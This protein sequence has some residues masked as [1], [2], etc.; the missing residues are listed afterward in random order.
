VQIS[1]IRSPSIRASG[2]TIAARLRGID[3]SWH[4]HNHRLPGVRRIAHAPRCFIGYRVGRRQQHRIG[5]VHVAA[6]D[7]LPLVADQR[8]DRG[9]GIVQVAG[10][11]RERMAEDM[12][13]DVRG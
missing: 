4:P 7:G 13:R 8:T 12:R 11:R 5:C 2:G 3:D 10:K 9:F 1:Q 6:S